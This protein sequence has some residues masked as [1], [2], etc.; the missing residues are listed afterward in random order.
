MINMGLTRAEFNDLCALLV[1]HHHIRVELSLMDLSHRHLAN[2]SNKLLGGQVNMDATGDE[3]TRTASVEL[4]DP[5]HSL[6]LDGDSPEDGSVYYTRMIRIVYIVQNVERTQSYRIPIFT[7]PLVKVDRSGPV[8]SLEAAGKEKLSMSAV[9]KG[10]TFKKGLKKTFVI[11]QIMEEL[12]GEAAKYLTI[13]NRTVKLPQKLSVN[14]E[15]T[16]WAVARNI[17]KSMGMQLFYDGYGRGMLRKMPGKSVY[18]FRAKGALLSNPQAT[19]DTESVA[20]A[21][22]IIGGKPKGAKKKVTYR[23]VAPRTHALSP[24]AMGRF[25][26]PR[27][28]PETV[29]QDSIRS[30]KDARQLARATLKNRLAE[31]VDVSFDSL[32][33][34]FLEENDLCRVESDEFSGNFR[35][36]KMT[37]PLVASGVS[38]VGYLKRVTPNRR[39]IRIRN[40]TRRRQ[41]R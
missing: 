16:A 8:L 18:V 34:P 2:L 20:N 25:G 17:A 35:L 4:L 14:R 37:I 32:P 13:P 1:T 15:T 26:N 6:K 33:I 38:T 30:V 27:Y 10:K 23:L 24:V 19:F 9:W 29:E 41:K 28:I 31:S 3:A 36:T 12:A 7:G 21:V 11:R 39:Q 40:N 22:E 5:T